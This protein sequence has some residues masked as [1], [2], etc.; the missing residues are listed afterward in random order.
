M[1]VEFQRVVEVAHAPHL[2]VGED[3]GLPESAPLPISIN[4]QFV[5]AVTP[6]TETPGVVI[7]KLSDGR[8]YA[9]RGEYAEIKEVLEGRGRLLA[10]PGASH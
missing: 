9:V 2:G 7:I 4:P 3:D 8:G 5:A 10:G 1:L 6:S